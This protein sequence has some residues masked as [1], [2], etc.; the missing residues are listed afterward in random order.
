MFLLHFTDE[1]GNEY[2]TI[3]PRL[4]QANIIDNTTHGYALKGSYRLTPVNGLARELPCDVP[5]AKERN[6]QDG[7]A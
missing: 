4:T 2:V 5:M 7:K 1:H 3:T 6:L